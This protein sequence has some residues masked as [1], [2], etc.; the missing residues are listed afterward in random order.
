VAL[1]RVRIALQSERAA[2]SNFAQ[3]WPRYRA[4]S[5]GT[6]K[7]KFTGRRWPAAS[8]R[9]VLTWRPPMTDFSYA[10]DAN[11]KRFQNLL[12]TSVD[13]TERQILQRLLEEEKAKAVLQAP[14]PEKK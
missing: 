12:E 3:N 11:I 9:M 8:G 1:L 4:Q 14:E 10:T 5:G 6:A 13:A 2:M 7:P